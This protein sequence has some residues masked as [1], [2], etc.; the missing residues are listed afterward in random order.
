MVYSWKRLTAVRG[1]EGRGCLKEDE[2]ISQGTYM[3]DSWTWKMDYGVG[4]QAR[5]RGSKRGIIGT[6]VNHKNNK[7]IKT[8][9]KFIK[10]N[11]KKQRTQ[12]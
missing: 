6:T 10:I 11:K 2:G 5:W 3:K 1:E 4:G 9:Q 8:F 7:L 12:K